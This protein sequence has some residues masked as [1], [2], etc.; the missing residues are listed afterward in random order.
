MTLWIL[1]V[2]W[3]SFGPCWFLQTKIIKWT[4][5]L[6]LFLW[7]FRNFQ[8]FFHQF[9][10]YFTIAIIYRSLSSWEFI[11]ISLIFFI[12]YREFLFSRLFYAHGLNQRRKVLTMT[13]IWTYLGYTILFISFL[14]LSLSLFLQYLLIIWSILDLSFFLLVIKFFEPTAKVSNNMLRTYLIRS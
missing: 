13:L 3:W 1:H 10:F 12:Y 14:C 6:N 4:L 9:E 11:R 5:F 7:C 2:R 8:G